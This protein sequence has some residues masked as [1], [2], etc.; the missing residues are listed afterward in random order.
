[1]LSRSRLSALF[2][3]VALAA[4]PFLAPAQPYP[5]RPLK[6]VVTFPPG[7]GTDVLAR[8][9]AAEISPLLGQPVI[10]D[11]KPGATGNIGADF[12]AKSAPDGYTLLIVNS[13]FAINAGLYERLP[14][15]TVKD[16]SPVILFAS[17]P[18]F[19]AVAPGLKVNSLKELIALAKAQPGKLSYASCGSGSPQHLAAELLKSM[20]GI[21]LAHIPYKGCA[22][23]LVDVTGGH[24]PVSFNTAANTIAHTKSGKL[25]ALATTGKQRFPLAPEVPTVEEAG[26]L[27]GYDV[28]Q[29]Y[30]VLGP[31]QT[32]QEVVDKLNAT[33]NK[34][35][36]QKSMQE[37]MLAGGWAAASGTPAQFSAVIRSDVERYTR[38]ARALKLKVD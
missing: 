31:A 12:V 5:S 33:I 15:D 3:G 20:A 34:V 7:G 9:L 29:W 30:G 16:F 26:G 17:V 23:A 22:P 25:I 1:M 13:A 35:M 24:V 11:N 4:L 6:L 19:I 27:A 14:F 10:A 37:R 21:D 28:D 32:P 2:L 38:Q 8:M 18:S 36:Q